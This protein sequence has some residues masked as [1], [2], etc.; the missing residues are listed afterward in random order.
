MA[1][2]LITAAV[3]IPIGVLIL[4]LNNPHVIAVVTTLLSVVAVYEV[5]SAAKYTKSDDL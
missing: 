2:R 4:V 1:K 3:G 5:L